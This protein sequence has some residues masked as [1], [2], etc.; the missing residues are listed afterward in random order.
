MPSFATDIDLLH[1][2]PRLMQDA[3]AVAQ[4]LLAGTADLSGSVLTLTS[5]SLTDA[6]I[7]T[8]HV[9]TLGDPV[10][11][12]FPIV[13]I[14]SSTV[15]SLSVLHDQLYPAEG[16]G[17]PWAPF[18][19]SGI[20]YSI[21]TFWPQRAI[22]SELLLQAARVK[23]QNVASILNPEVLKRPCVL[24]SLQ[25]IYTAL[26]AAASEPAPLLVRAELYERLYRRALGAARIDLDFNG[27]GVIDT[28]RLLGVLQ[29]QRA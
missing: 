28:S 9:V 22:V 6:P 11:G 15:L 7:T 1:W 24:G 16:A 13:S 10:A 21:R 14:N 8:E 5:G 3:A 27:D 2:E 4:T 23:R 18:S 25:M 26:A 20:G 12:S 19:G 17:E 29:L